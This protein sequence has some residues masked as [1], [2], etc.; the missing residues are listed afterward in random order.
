MAVSGLNQLPVVEGQELLGVISIA[1]ESHVVFFHN[2]SFV[3]D[4]SCSSHN[5]MYRH[6]IF[7]L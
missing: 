4:F 7:T 6:R 3:Y 1:G 2:K 5:Y